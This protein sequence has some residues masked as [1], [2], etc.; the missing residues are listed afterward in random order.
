MLLTQSVNLRTIRRRMIRLVDF[1]GGEIADVDVGVEARFEGGTDL[2]EAIPGDAAEEVVGFDFG[3]AVVAGCG[4]EAVRGGTEEA[5]NEMTGGITKSNVFREVEV[6]APVDDFAIGVVRVFGAEGR[7]T[8]E[9][10]EHDCANGPP[11]TAEC[12]AFPGE[13]FR[14][15][16]IRGSDGRVCHDASR[17][18]PS[19]DLAA[20]AN[21]KINLVEVDGNAVVFWLG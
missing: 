19:I 8:D 4:A 9:T 15:D 21:C 17:F 10:L 16:V 20:I 13:D 11:V 6:F 14:G 7:P 12:I 2:A 18:A 1:I 5:A 3:G